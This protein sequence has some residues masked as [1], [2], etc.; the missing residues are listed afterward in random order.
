MIGK[1]EIMGEVGRGSMGI[2][3]QAYDPFSD[4]QVAIKV[5]HPQFVRPDEDALR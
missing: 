5:A 3:Y 2:V 1:Y 4:K